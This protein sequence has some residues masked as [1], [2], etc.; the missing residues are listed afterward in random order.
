MKPSFIVSPRS[1]SRQ[2]GAGLIELMISIAIGLILVAL[3]TSYYLSSRQSYQSTVVSS[4]VIDS[5]RYAMQLITRQ[6]L[7]AGYSDYWVNRQTEFPA[8]PSSADM[9]AFKEAQ[10]VSGDDDGNIWLRL[11]PA[12]LEGQQIKGCNNENLGNDIEQFVVMQLGVKDDEPVLFCRRADTNGDRVPLLNGVEALA[13]D[14]LDDSNSFKAASSVTDWT[15]VRAVRVHL[16]LRSETSTFDAPVSQ[17]FTWL[18]DERTFNDRQMRT[19]VS[20]VVA[21]RN[22]LGEL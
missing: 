15:S 20:R 5:Q 21:L 12:A 22:S 6:L 8:T 19:Q 10:L 11:R 13:F 14:Y 3:V 4:E 1:M 7:L 17:T 2:G 9:P 18:G 16:L